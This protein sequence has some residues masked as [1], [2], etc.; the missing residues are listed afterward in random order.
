MWLMRSLVL[1]LMSTVATSPQAAADRRKSFVLVIHGGAGVISR[2]HMSPEL[3]A[4][5]R[6]ALKAALQAGY[7]LLNTHGTGLEAV[8]A[9]I[10]VMEDSPLFN[11]GHGAVLNGAGEVELDAAIMDGATRKAGAVAA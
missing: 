1:E 7:D 4:E 10:R 9:A 3:E 5:Y 8:G 6:A 2:Q 11:A